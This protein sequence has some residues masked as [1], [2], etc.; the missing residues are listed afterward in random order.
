MKI[1]YQLPRERRVVFKPLKIL[2]EKRKDQLNYDD[3]KK[4][5]KEVRDQKQERGVRRK[6]ENYTLTHRDWRDMHF[7]NLYDLR[8]EA[9]K[10]RLQFPIVRYFGA[11]KKGNRE[12][13]T[14]LAQPLDP[15]TAIVPETQKLDA[16][17]DNLDKF[18]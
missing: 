10:K 16:L 6:E 5:R 11:Y 17:L 9:D 13:A 8:L 18:E 4:I 14:E 3:L 1:P 2:E 15:T 12:A 7:D